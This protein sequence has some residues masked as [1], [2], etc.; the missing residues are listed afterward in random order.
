MNYSFSDKIKHLKPSAIREILKHTSN[1]GIIPFA[2]GNPAAESFPIAQMEEIAA[3]IFK[4]NPVQAFQYSITEG[5]PPLREKTRARLAEKWDS[6]KEFDDLIIVS[7]GQQGIDLTCK[8]LCN[9][10]DTVICENPSFI[11]ALNAFRSYNVNL[12][13]IPLEDDGMDINALENALKTQKNVRFIYIIP[14]FQNPAGICTSFNKRKA[15]YKLAQK[16][17]V[18][19]LEDN[20]YGELRFSGENIPAIKSMDTDGRVVYAGSYSKILSAGIRLGFVCAPSEIISK[21]TVAKQV[22]DVHTNIFFQILAD[23]FISRYGLDNHIE[24]IKAIYRRKSA[25][26]LDGIE[27]HFPENIKYSRPE[28]GLFVWC[29]APEGT[30]IFALASRLIE[31]KVAIV[32]GG[33]FVA[34]E[35]MPC[36][37]FRLNFSTPS[38]EQIVRG[39]EILG[40]ELKLL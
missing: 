27:R 25:L 6:V 28:G 40:D 9:E 16:Y 39:I 4:N 13:G 18:F 7:G 32:P 23:E 31:K 38:D 2:A 22:N 26:M 29:R 5:Y 10:G 8:V 3:D 30:D 12:S 21:I 1:P 11:G 15:I 33:A 37:A 35:N 36:F 20:P 34:D 17:N 19:I 14:T 24:N